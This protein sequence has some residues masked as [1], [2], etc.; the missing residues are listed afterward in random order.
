MKTLADLKRDIQVGDKIIMTFNALQGSSDRIKQF[1][2]VERYIISKNTMGV[3]ISPDK[4]AT[5][6]SFLDY[7]K[8]A[9]L[10]EYDGKTLKIY[11]AGFR[12]L[13]ED[14]KR[15]K[16]N[17]PSRRIE[18]KEAVTIELMTDGSGFYWKDKQY[19][20]DNNM[21]YLAG[22]ETFR[23]LRYHY[24]TGMIEDESIKGQLS[25]EYNFIK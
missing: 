24:N 21:E 9:T 22:H 5:K 20:K 4:N 17:V 2:G 23:G 18:N 25:L 15:V 3:K 13:T 11:D 12:E 16:D 1:I 10:C 19:Y 14:E 6:G 8:K 7:P